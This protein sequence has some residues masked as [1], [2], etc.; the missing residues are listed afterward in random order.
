MTA[1]AEERE[2]TYPLG[3]VSRI[4]GLSPD[5]LRAWERR[6]RVVAPL[7]TPG[8]TRRYRPSDLERL[9]LLKAA[10]D[11]GHRIGDVAALDNAEIERRLCEVERIPS[12]RAEVIEA[13]ERLDGPSVER[14]VSIQLAALGPLRFAR[15]F[16]LPLLTEIGEGW[17]SRRLCVASEHLASGLLRSLLG[18]A[19]R[20]TRISLAGR[21]ILFATPSGERH[22]L[23]LLVAA[24]T[25]LGAGGNAV[26]L[27][28]ELPVDEL[29]GAAERSGAAGLAIS[30]VAL[31][32]SEAERVVRELRAELPAA[33]ALWLGGP[34]AREIRMPGGVER[35]E[36]LDALEAR[37]GLL[38]LRAQKDAT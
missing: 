4:T 32:V 3:A 6:H 31:A 16:A 13:L 21:P 30:L 25:A 35:F 14:L 22:E 2:R 11:A 20:P 29:V 9:R 28:P 33:T 26:Y 7:R 18:S 37:V 10:V 24:L 1:K 23:G 8:G 27:G 17:A 5:V 38:N 12:G 19:L 15:D 34:R 36:S